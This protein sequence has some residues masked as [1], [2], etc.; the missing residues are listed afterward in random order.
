LIVVPLQDCWSSILWYLRNRCLPGLRF[1]AYCNC[2]GF[3]ELCQRAIS[4][5]ALSPEDSTSHLALMATLRWGSFVGVLR[6]WEQNHFPHLVEWYLW[7]DSSTDRGC[8][9]F[10]DARSELV[11]FLWDC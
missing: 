8:A 4:G 7:R 9:V 3:M 2:W 6:L 11:C 10:W 1:E 5:S